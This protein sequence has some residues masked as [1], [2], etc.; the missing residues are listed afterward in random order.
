[1]TTNGVKFKKYAENLLLA[2]LNSVNIS[3]DSLKSERILKL[4]GQSTFKHSMAAIIKAI[5]VGFKRVKVCNY[6]TF[7]KYFIRVS[8]H[9]GM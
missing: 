6:F 5:E 1:M 2:G 7:F 9:H 3:L 8:F 4:T